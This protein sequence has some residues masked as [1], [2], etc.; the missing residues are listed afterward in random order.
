[1]IPALSDALDAEWSLDEGDRSKVYDDA[2]S[3]PIVK[4]TTVIGNPTI[5]RG[6]NLASRGLLPNEM[7]LMHANDKAQCEADLEAAIPWITG[8]TINRQVAIYSL[9]FNM[10][11]GDVA[12]FVGQ[13]GW[14]NFLE[15]MRIG[16]YEDAAHNLETTQPWASEVR[17]RAARLAS[18]I[19]SG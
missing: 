5:A 2:T 16:A 19:R 18:L 6:R 13:H 10:Y 9:Y 14:P 17:S 12:R 3:K 7:D 4:G 11:L 15:Q 1:M 8:V